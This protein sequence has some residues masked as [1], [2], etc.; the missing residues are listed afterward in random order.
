MKHITLLIL[1]NILLLHAFGQEIAHVFKNVKIYTINKPVIEN[2]ALVIKDGKIIDVGVTGKV[3]IPSLAMEYDMNGK[4]IIPGMVDTHSHLGQGDG[5]DRSSA[6]NPDVRIMDAINPA[7]DGF[8]R[9]LAGG[10]TTLNIM[11]G[12]GHLMSGQTVYLKL[13]GGNTIEDLLFCKN[14]QTEICGGMKMANGTNSINEKPFPGTRAK[15]AAMVRELFIRAQEYRQQIDDFYN[16]SKDDKEA[17]LPE[18][19]LQMEALVQILKGQRIVHFHTHRH[20]DILTAIRLSQEFKFRL[21]LHHVSEGWKVAKEIAKAGVP[22][23]IIVIDSPG[24]KLEAVYLLPDCGKYLEE[25]GVDVAFHTDDPITDSRRFLRSAAIG[26]REGMSREKALEALT[27]AGARMLGLDKVIGSLEVGKD[28][29]FV[30]LSGDPFSIYTKVEETWIEGLKVF[31]LKKP[32]DKKYAV[33]GYNVYRSKADTH[34]HIE[35]Y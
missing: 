5:G 24:G 26:V 3:K 35:E 14:T 33:G 16:N 25:A 9:A 13:R 30:V 32:E 2:G 23:S 7:S 28:A 31:D 15:S 6:L 19:D 11:P 12:S 4:V 18:R 27:L 1:L 17:K 29:D 22:A 34:V 10:I 20:D 8:K 21:V